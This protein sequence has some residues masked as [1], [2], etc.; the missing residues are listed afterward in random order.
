MPLETFKMLNNMS[1]PVLSNLVKLPAIILPAILGIIIFY[2][3][4][5][6]AQP[7]LVRRVSAMQR[8]SCGTV[9]QMSSGKKVISI[10]SK[11]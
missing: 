1:P 10:N 8:Q 9:F 2:R 3:Y 6:S 4:P 11:R 7:N 5:E